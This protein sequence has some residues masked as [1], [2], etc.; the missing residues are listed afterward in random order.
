MLLGLNSELENSVILTLSECGNLS[1]E[2]MLST[3]SEKGR[4]ISLQGLYRVL[5]KL[6]L[7]KVI[8]K[9]KHLYSLRL[10]WIIELTQ[11]VDQLEQ[12][13]LRSDHLTQLLPTNTIQKRIW[14]FNNLMKLVEAWMQIV[15]AMSKASEEKVILT[16]APHLWF[17]LV[18]L[19]EWTQFKKVLSTFMQRQY[20]LIHGTEFV[21]KYLNALTKLPEEEVFMND[22]EYIEDDLTLYRTIIDDTILTVRL[23]P[24]TAKKIATLF[25]Q[26]KSEETMYLLDIFQTF[27][28]KVRVTIMIKKD[29]AA[30]RRYRKKFERLFGPIFK[31]VS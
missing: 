15:I 23:D 11:L 28:S 18:H 6:Q 5:K 27:T 9:E 30:A 21:D 16:A 26:I 25:Q 4:T 22:A 31:K 19:P 13:Y 14:R 1:A 17:A 20:T 29:P 2:E 7:E 24:V 3:M 10:P 8:V 12:V